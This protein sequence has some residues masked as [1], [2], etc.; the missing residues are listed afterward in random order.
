[1][2][3]KKNQLDLRN[4]F[5]FKDFPIRGVYVDLSQSLQYIIS[6]KEYPE[7]IQQLMAELLAAV[8]LLSSTIK[9]KGQLILQLQGKGLLR[10]LVAEATSYGTCRATAKLA[11]N[12]LVEDIPL[13][14][15]T[16]L[17]EDAVF[18]VTM[19]PENGEMW[20]GIVPFEGNSIAEILTNYM[21]RS[22]QLDT[23]FKFAY[24]KN[25]IKGL[26]LQRLPGEIE[27]VDIES[28][29]T[30]S[31]L[32][33][34]L[35]AEELLTLEIKKILHRLF[36]EYDITLYDEEYFEFMCQCSQEKISKILLLLSQDEI[37]EILSEQGSLEF[38]C[39]YCGKK[40]VFDKDDVNQILG[41]DSLDNQIV[42]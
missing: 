13:D 38:S 35:S 22:E 16:L 37:K 5:L 3:V 21:I 4:R 18:V 19:Q 7:T 24:T 11:E 10:L 33:E 29:E 40:Y 39:E 23:F 25:H 8:V 31:V 32:V 20:Q 27:D 15:K 14:L 36:H 34:S 30:I 42:H 1:M 17:G 28:W 41:S 12:L 2:S 6:L 9:F 26:L